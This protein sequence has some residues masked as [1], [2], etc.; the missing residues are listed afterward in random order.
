MIP[1][2]IGADIPPDAK[3][4][5]ASTPCGNGAKQFSLGKGPGALEGPSTRPGSD[6]N[7]VTLLG[8][9]SMPRLERIAD[10]LQ[11]DITKEVI[12]ILKRLI[13]AIIRCHHAS[14]GGWI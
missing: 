5:W 6:D 13:C 4:D 12:W 7:D 8:D 1:W 9:T 2:N 10:T 11:R 14:L 3:S